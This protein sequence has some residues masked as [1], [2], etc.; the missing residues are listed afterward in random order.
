MAKKEPKAK[1]MTLGKSKFVHTVRTEAYDRK[2]SEC[3]QVRKY[4]VAGK[5]D[6]KAKGISPEAALSLDSCEACATSVIAEALIPAEDKRSNRAEVRDEVLARAKGATNK[7]KRVKAAKEAVT[8]EAKPKAEKKPSM[9]KSGPRSVASRADGDPAEAK[10]K[11]LAEFGTEHGWKT[12]IGK[13]EVTGHIVVTAKRGD[14]V[15]TAWFIDGKY[16]IN[17]HAET[18]VGSWVGK[19]RGAHA[20]RRQMAGEGRDRVH[21]EPGKGRSGPRKKDAEPDVPE[22]ESPEDA[23]RRVPF[24]L[25]DEAIVIMDAVKG[26]IVRWRNGTSGN[27]EEATLSSKIKGKKRD[28]IAV[29]QHP[30]TGR[31]ML[32]FIVVDSVGEHGEVYGPE[33]SIYLDKIVRVVG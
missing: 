5:I 29:N 7:G 6:Y 28:L 20:A 16:D 13:D 14:E 31:R 19:L 10:A 22:D 8:K 11:M 27:V 4:M 3:Q 25:D 17:R 24:S 21:P 32:T 12:S 26:K 33:R 15:I 9:T 2:N 18:R 1:F 30:K 23:A